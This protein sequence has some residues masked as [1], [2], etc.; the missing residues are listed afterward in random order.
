MPDEVTQAYNCTTCNSTP[1]KLCVRLALE[2]QHL[3]GT[4]A[5]HRGQLL[6]LVLYPEILWYIRTLKNDKFAPSTQKNVLNVHISGPTLKGTLQ[7]KR[8]V[9][10]FHKRQ[11]KPSSGN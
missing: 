6:Q 10:G 8:I 5:I 2:F 3:L 9:F 7:T 4:G 11:R 1:H